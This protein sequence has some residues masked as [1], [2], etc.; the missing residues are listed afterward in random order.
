MDVDYSM[1]YIV[2]TTVPTTVLNNDVMSN[3]V[4]WFC[5]NII[6]T[7]PLENGIPA[8]FQMDWHLIS[9]EKMAALRTAA[10]ALSYVRR[11]VHRLRQ[12]LSVM[13]L[14]AVKVNAKKEA[15]S[16]AILVAH[17][18]G[19][20]VVKSYYTVSHPRPPDYTLYDDLLHYMGVTRNSV[21]YLERKVVN[22]IDLLELFDKYSRAVDPMESWLME[23][24]IGEMT[25]SEAK[26]KMRQ[27]LMLQKDVEKA[28]GTYFK[29]QGS[30]LSADVITNPHTIQAWNPNFQLNQTLEM[31]Q[32]RIAMRGKTLLLS[33]CSLQGPSFH[34]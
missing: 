12:F 29:D 23:L 8:H 28:W 26:F 15:I 1:P 34:Q 19:N 14:Q 27:A 13:E 11:T 31:E 22:G 30:L 5:E 4:K 10:P 32:L 33:C 6:S 17:P 25:L 18:Q 9:D 3:I 21:T 24:D 20:D 7:Q 2:D 16:A